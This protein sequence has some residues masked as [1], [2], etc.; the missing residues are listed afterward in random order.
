M[1]KRT[2]ITATFR[3]DDLVQ[4]RRRPRK[5]NTNTIIIVLVLILFGLFIL[6]RTQQSG[7]FRPQ[8]ASLP[9]R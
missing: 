6:R 5:K 8:P 2:R 1:A 9:R 3:E 7:G 4:S